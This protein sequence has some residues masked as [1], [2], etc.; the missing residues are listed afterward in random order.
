M[1]KKKLKE[2]NRQPCVSEPSPSVFDSTLLSY[3]GKTRNII[4]TA[5]LLLP[6]LLSTSAALSHTYVNTHSISKSKEQVASIFRFSTECLSIYTR[7]LF[8]TTTVLII[9]FSFVSTWQHGRLSVAAAA[10]VT[11]PVLSLSLSLIFFIR[12]HS[13]IW[14]YT[15]FHIRRRGQIRYR[16]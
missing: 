13:C 1:R 12:C 9:S 14:P 8:I 7:P 6:L 15:L 4:T 10:P 16:P 11:T 2:K 3:I 5:P